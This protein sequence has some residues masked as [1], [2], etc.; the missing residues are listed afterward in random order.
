MVENIVFIFISMRTETKI[1]GLDP[2]PLKETFT[3]MATER[4]G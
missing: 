3:S 2:W 4:F 1:I